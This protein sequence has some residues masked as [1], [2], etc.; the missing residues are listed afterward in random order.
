MPQI[1]LN[2]FAVQ[3]RLELFD[4]HGLDETPIQCSYK[5]GLNACRMIP[6]LLSRGSESFKVYSRLVVGA[7]AT[8]E[9]LRK[10][11]CGKELQ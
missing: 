2:K 5:S 8:Y 3:G 10:N 7:A 11:L 9:G 4:R 6:R 1:I